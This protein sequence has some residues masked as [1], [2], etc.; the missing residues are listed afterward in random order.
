MTYV[1]LLAASLLVAGCT[2]PHPAPPA[3]DA[4]HWQAMA[5]T[6]LDAM[7]AFVKS[8]HPGW[9]DTH[10]PGFRRRA[11]DSYT[12]AQA[13]LPDVA[14]DA[15]AMVALRRYAA[16]YQDGH[17]G[18][19]DDTGPRLAVPP[20]PGAAAPENGF[21]LQDGTLWIRAA[22]FWPDQPAAAALESMLV[23]LA[24]ARDVA[25][26]VF[27]TRANRGGD[28]SVGQRMFDAATGGLQFDDS[29]APRMVAQWRVSRQSIAKLRLHRQQFDTLYGPGSAQV[30]AVAGLLAQLEAAQRD[31]QSWVDQDGGP[32]FT[33]SDMVQ[34]HATLRRF[35]GTV[36]LVTDAACASACLDFADLVLR[37]PGAVHLG[38]ATASDTVYL[39]V[40][41][42][43]LPSG[44]H[45]RLPVKVWRNRPRGDSQPLVPEIALQVDLQDDTA[46]YQATLAA[47]RQRSS[48]RNSCLPGIKAL[49]PL[50]VEDP[51]SGHEP[52][53]RGMNSILINGP[54]PA[55]VVRQVARR[56]ATKTPQPDMKP[57]VVGIHVLDMDGAG[58]LPDIK[59]GQ[60]PGWH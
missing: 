16:A 40:T 31:G 37:V 51:D 26:I 34:R 54:A 35:T 13:L 19:M 14:S 41:D 27:D 18:Y 47:L 20:A 57:A 38:A 8:T 30:R 49:Y 12:A 1:L 59:A 28:S 33:R 24:A 15:A 60:T 50:S 22:D 2:L 7:H 45:F 52:G 53:F 23:Q 48:P 17:V 3:N 21:T 44:N 29:A 9:I 6:D 43:L 56:H 25:R 32:S 39:D 5:A 36:A 58:G 42:L 55:G 4:A 46:V 10:N 11:E